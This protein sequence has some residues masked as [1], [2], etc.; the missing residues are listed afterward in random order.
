M[1]SKDP[2]IKVESISKIYRIGL[3]ESINENFGA[4]IFNFLKSPFKNYRKYRS[5]YRFDD[6]DSA[7]RQDVGDNASDIIWA[8]RD[9]SFNVK[10]GE[11]L[12]IIGRNGAGKSTLLK[13]LCKI[14][15]PTYGSVEIR[16]R[17]SSLLEVGTGFHPELTGR[18]NIYL[19]GT[20][21]GMRK[22]EVDSKFE[23]IVH[24]SGVEKFINT[25][26]KRYSSGMRVRLAFSVA[27]H[28]EPEI[29][30]IDEVLAVGDADFQ[31]KCLNKMEDIGQKGRTVLF[32]SHNMSAVTRLCNRALLIED[33]RLTDDG[34]AD[35]L[36][37]SYLTSDLGTTA[38]REWPDPEKAPA[39]PVARLRA[40]RVKKE[41]GEIS[42]TFD[43]RHPIIVEIEYDVLES[44]HIMLPHFGLINELGQ[45]AFISVDLDPEWRRRPRPTGNYISK[46][47][48]PGNFLSEGMMYISC[49]C[50]TL[51]PDTVQFSER[52]AVAFHV[53]DSLDGDSARG[54]FATH[55]PGVVRPVLDWMTEYDANRR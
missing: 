16:G 37:S 27:A 1:N 55:L 10:Q 36:V 22:R 46:A 53:V 48:I 49:H 42:E 19:N 33:G 20:I 13:I 40:L 9:I 26:V 45:C 31:K 25:P 44:G 18:E 39:G 28:L 29:L 15:D 3:K 34:P 2:A 38:A 21:L 5:L 12:G 50:L 30:I 7:Q 14:T 11:V 54:D 17:I 52:K 23:E 24:F 6:V 35:Q 43:I 47:I 41:S 51:N 8:L 4:T 32:V